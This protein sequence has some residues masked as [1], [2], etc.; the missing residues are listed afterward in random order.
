MNQQ[1][2]QSASGYTSSVAPFWRSNQPI[3]LASSLVRRL[4]CIGLPVLI[5][6][7][8]SGVY[9]DRFWD[10]FLEFISHWYRW[11]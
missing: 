7:L 9:G 8:F 4:L 2:Q 6:A 1:D 3:L 10:G 11:G 5:V